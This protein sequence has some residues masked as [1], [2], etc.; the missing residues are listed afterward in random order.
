MKKITVHEVTLTVSFDSDNHQEAAEMAAELVR[1]CEWAAR[2]IN[3]RR[4]PFVFERPVYS[5]PC[6]HDDGAD[7][8]G[9]MVHHDD[10]F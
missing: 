8:G 6:P 1:E 3:D 10:P 5:P 9:E 7:D 4:N 2:R